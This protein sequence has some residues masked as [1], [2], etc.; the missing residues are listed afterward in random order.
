MFA[1]SFSSV[2]AVKNQLLQ[3]NPNCVIRTR[4]SSNSGRNVRL[5]CKHAGAGCPLN[6]SCVNSGLSGRV[7]MSAVTY[8]YGTCSALKPAP[9][10][11]SLA[12]SAL[13]AS[14]ESLAPSAESVE[15]CLCS[16]LCVLPSCPFTRCRNGHIFCKGCFNGMVRNQVTG[17]GKVRFVS[18]KTVYCRI[19]K[20]ETDIA[21]HEAAQHL[22]T[23]VWNQYLAGLSEGAVVAEQQ[24]FENILQRV[25]SSVSNPMEDAMIIV[26]SK[27]Q[28]QCPACSA[29]NQCLTAEHWSTDKSSGRCMCLRPLKPTSMG[30]STA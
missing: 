26:R 3:W 28:P 6:V 21:M 17:V 19:C 24:R 20:P 12:P 11:E 7:K 15:C 25:A 23:D 8:R 10:A 4:G 5:G 22:T 29:S 2:E 27:I 16:L 1:V 9:S 13:A 18:T 30:T 14:T